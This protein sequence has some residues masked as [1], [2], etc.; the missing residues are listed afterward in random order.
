MLLQQAQADYDPILLPGRQDLLSLFSYP[1]EIC[2]K[3]DEKLGRKEELIVRK[4]RYLFTSGE[5]NLLLRG[6][7][8]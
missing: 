4:S 3:L 7:V 5:D 8:R 6:V 2:S 1:L